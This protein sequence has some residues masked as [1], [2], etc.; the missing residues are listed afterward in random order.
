VSASAAAFYRVARI[1]PYSIPMI[2]ITLDVRLVLETDDKALMCHGPAEV[3]AHMSRGEDVD[4]S[5]YHFRTSVAFE[6]A[7][8]EYDWLNRIIAVG[9]G[10]HLPKGSV[11]EVFEVL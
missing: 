6:M 11:Y 9:T 8:A 7:A 4:P 5:D 2:S 10:R 1:G 3:I